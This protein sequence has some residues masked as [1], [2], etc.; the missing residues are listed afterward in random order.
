M[1]TLMMWVRSH[2]CP[3]TDVW[4]LQAG[5][6]TLEEAVWSGE[7]GREVRAEHPPCM[8]LFIVFCHGT[9]GTTGK[10]VP[11]NGFAKWCAGS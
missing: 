10:C 6:R 9:K 7:R 4:K 11:I 3:G 8:G 5:N 2:D 1:N